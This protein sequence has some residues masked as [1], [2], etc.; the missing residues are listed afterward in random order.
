MRWPEHSRLRAPAAEDLPAKEW[1]K[2][3]AIM[4][5]ARGHRGNAE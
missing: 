1:W 2:G 4:Q 3:A 5:Y